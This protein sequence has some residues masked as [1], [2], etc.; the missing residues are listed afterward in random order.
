MKKTVFFISFLSV[1][2]FISARLDIGQDKIV[3][4]ND[5]IITS[6]EFDKYYNLK[7]KTYEQLYFQQTGRPLPEKEKPTK[8][9]LMQSMIQDELLKDELNKSKTFVMDETVYKNTMQANKDYYTKYRALKE[10]NYQFNEVD[11]KAYVESEYN[12]TYEEFDQNLKDSLK[13]QQYIMKKAEPKIQQIST[14]KYD[15]PKD[16]PVTM[17]NTQMGT[18]DKYYSL[19]E[20]YERNYAMF[21]RP[22]SVEVKHIFVRGVDQN[23]KGEI[24]KM[25]DVRYQAQ[26]AKAN[27]IYSRLLKGEKTFD[28][29]CLAY[30]EDDES[31]DFKDPETKKS[32]PGYLGPIAYSGELVPVYKQHFGEELYSKIFDLP[33]G[34]ISQVFE[35]ALGFHIF[36]VIDKKDVSIIKFDEAKIKL[37]DMFKE[38]ERNKAVTDELEKLVENLKSKAA[39]TYFSDEYKL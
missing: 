32:N 10:P 11:F 12:I 33:K 13:V 21:V 26:K 20:F 34:K 17:P 14:K 1:F 8:K 15:S 24:I 19:L 30:S 4:V 6:K 38:Y 37:I 5:K 29:L 7:I 35:G 28:E 2:I 22:K 39:I 36:Y 25:Q 3:K 23:E 16:F 27:D 9:M 18:E 31:R